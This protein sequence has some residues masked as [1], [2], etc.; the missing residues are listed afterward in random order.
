MV[1]LKGSGWKEL[2][3]SDMEYELMKQVHEKKQADKARRQKLR[4]AGLYGILLNIIRWILVI[5]EH[6]IS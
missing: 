3:W 2:P 4:N 6:K 5:T 1:S